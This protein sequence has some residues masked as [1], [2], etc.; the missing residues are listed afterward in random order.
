MTFREKLATERPKYIGSQF[1][2]GCKGCPKNYKYEKETPCKRKDKKVNN[3]SECWDREI[4]NSSHSKIFVI[5]GMATSGKST[6]V[7]FCKKYNDNVYEVSTVDF[8]KDVAKYA[9]WNGEKNE[10][11][12]KFLSDLKDAMEVYGDIPNK[13][14]YE[15]IKNHPDGIIF[16]NAREPHNIDYYKQK[17]NALSILVNNP[18][19]PAVASN[20]ADANVFN[21]TYDITIHNDKLLADLQIKAKTFMEFFTF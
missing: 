4:P 2:G 1:E 20:H 11:G 16:V 8:V 21:Y 19:V 9:G 7:T 12:R 18:N 6:F 15:F 10:V 17:Y 5:N 14:I 3:C 13:K